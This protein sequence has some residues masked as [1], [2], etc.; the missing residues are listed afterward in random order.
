MS[1]G[2]KINQVRRI[3]T[4]FLKPIQ[5]NRNKL[6]PYNNQFG[7]P[8]KQLLPNRQKQRMPLPQSLPNHPHIER[9]AL[10]G[11]IRSR[12]WSSKINRQQRKPVRHFQTN[13]QQRTRLGQQKANQQLRQ[14]VRF[15]KP[16]QPKRNRDGAPQPI[17]QQKGR[18][19]SSQTN[20]QQRSRI[21]S[22]HLH[23]E[24]GR[25]HPEKVINRIKF[26]TPQE[27]LLF[28][29]VQEKAMWEMIVNRLPPDY[30]IPDPQFLQV[31]KS[32]NNQKR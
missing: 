31:Y 1:R 11:Q 12:I 7:R 2:Q 28:A 23:S 32:F 16:N 27:L 8:I 9:S 22:S 17:Q 25:R 6:S 29:P 19:R 4:R 13:Q 10:N 5:A 18:I 3:Q 14:R 20:R 26:F 24:I 21:R 15:P 30:S